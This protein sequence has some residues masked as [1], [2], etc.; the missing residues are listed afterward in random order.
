VWK[1]ISTH[2]DIGIHTEIKETRYMKKWSIM[3]GALVIIAL[4]GSAF[5]LRNN[6]ENNKPVEI[7]QT[8]TL[9]LNSTD[10]TTAQTSSSSGCGGS[11]CSPGASQDAG[12]TERIRAY[13]YDYYSNELGDTSIKVDV[14]NLGCHHEAS[15]TLEGKIIKRLSINGGSIT[16]IT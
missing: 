8:E 13:L 1:R 11:C 16:D 4:A 14:Q 2:T 3:T 5:A 10:T 12:L 7:A 9:E 15:V 6:V